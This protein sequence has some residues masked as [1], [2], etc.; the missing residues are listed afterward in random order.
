[1]SVETVIFL[2]L[3]IRHCNLRWSHSWF[4]ILGYLQQFEKDHLINPYSLGH[5]SHPFLPIGH[6]QVRLSL[7]FKA[8]PS[9]KFLS[10]KL[11]PISIWMKT[12]FH[13]KDFA[14]SLALKWRRRWTRKWPIKAK[15]LVKEA[16]SSGRCLGFECGRAGF[17][18]HPNHWLDLSSVESNLFHRHQLHTHVKW[19]EMFDV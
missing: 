14:L 15:D 7:S 10:C 11:V 13:K 19:Y 2:R 3:N 17:K 18:S 5:A 6:F 16:C 12:D 9:A 8:S 1:M 4:L